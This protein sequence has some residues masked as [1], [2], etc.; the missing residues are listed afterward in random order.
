MTEKPEENKSIL[1]GRRKME[2]DS[3]D[4]VSYGGCA[5]RL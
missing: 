4:L 5:V 1:N 3:S 2:A